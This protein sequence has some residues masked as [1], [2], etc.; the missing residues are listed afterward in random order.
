[1][2][3]I[4]TLSAIF[5]LAVFCAISTALPFPTVH[6]KNE[7]LADTGVSLSA[8]FTGQLLSETTIL[9]EDDATRITIEDAKK[10]FDAGDAIFVDAR[11]ADS[12][13]VE[14]IKGAVNIPVAELEK[15]YK[16]L[17]ENKTIIVYCS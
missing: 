3:F 7:R 12:Y 16:E 11:S 8:R 9:V 13:K 4:F 17:P 15:R 10:A 14:H 5:V 6:A 2:R 1:M